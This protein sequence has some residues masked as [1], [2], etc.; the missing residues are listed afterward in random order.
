MKTNKIISYTLI[1]YMII[2]LI[3]YFLIRNNY[4]LTESNDFYLTESNYE[5]K[6]ITLIKLTLCVIALLGT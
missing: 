1:S 6:E 3:H 2:D 4:A 5:S